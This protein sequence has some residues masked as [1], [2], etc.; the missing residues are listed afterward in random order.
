MVNLQIVKMCVSY[1]KQTVITVIKHLLIPRSKASSI[2]YICS[3]RVSSP[4]F[5]VLNSLDKNLNC[6]SIAARLNATHAGLFTDP[7]PQIGSNIRSIL[8][9]AK[10]GQK[11]LNEREREREKKTV[12]GLA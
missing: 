1:V 11:G 3:G 5:Q 7:G 4:L 10:S 8:C 2:V 9:K 6:L 12:F